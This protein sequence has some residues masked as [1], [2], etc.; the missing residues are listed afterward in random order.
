MICRFFSCVIF[1]SVAQFWAMFYS[2]QAIANTSD[3]YAGTVIFMRHTLAPGT[4]DPENFSIN[5]CKTQRNLNKAGQAQAKM[6]GAELAATN[7]EISAVYSSYWCRCMETANLLDIGPVSPFDGLNS[8]F[9]GHVPRDSTLKKL[10]RK[11]EDLPTSAPAV[12]MVTHYVIIHAITGLGVSSGGMVI[13]D[14]KTGKTEELL[15]NEL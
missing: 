1:L 13:Y 10:R 7:I 2:T 15:L 4:G 12:L 6:I 3:D 8:F 14:L 9:Q 11:L 5:D